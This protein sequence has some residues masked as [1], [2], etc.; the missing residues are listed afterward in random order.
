MIIVADCGS[1]TVDWR[2]TGESGDITAVKTAGVNFAVQGPSDLERILMDSLSPFRGQVSRVYFYGAGITGHKRKEQAR[3]VLARFFPEAVVH[4][5][6]DMAG[7][8][9]ALFGRSNGLACI[10]GTG[11]NV[12]Y[13]DGKDIVRVSRS[14]GFVLGDEGS[15][16]SHDVDEVMLRTRRRIIV[17][18]SL[19]HDVFDGEA[20]RLRLPGY[21]YHRRVIPRPSPP[22][23][24][25]RVRRASR[26]FSRAGRRRWGLC[27]RI[28]AGCP[29]R[30]C[31][32]G[33]GRRGRASSSRSS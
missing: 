18:E 23:C 7:A 12:C 15:A 24:A 28:R 26:I 31:I 21:A 27:R 9:V 17:P 4:A 3:A 10:L 29:R 8:A 14:G 2:I 16:V 1:T 19:A 20:L 11:S 5:D 13:Y 22:L 25:R 30:F 32:R 6:S 33:R